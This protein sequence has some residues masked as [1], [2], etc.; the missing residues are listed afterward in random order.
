MNGAAS[1]LCMICHNCWSSS[2]LCA[3]CRDGLLAEYMG[4]SRTLAERGLL[5]DTVAALETIE[6]LPVVSG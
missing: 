4:L 6:R 1:F 5:L 3:S 2:H